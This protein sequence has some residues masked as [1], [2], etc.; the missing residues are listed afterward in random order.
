MMSR[1]LGFLTASA[2]DTVCSVHGS[3][4][5]SKVAI[6]T[7]L[8]IVLSLLFIIGLLGICFL[9]E[10]FGVAFMGKIGGCEG[11]MGVH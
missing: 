1:I 11:K 4:Q 9:G 10:V 5:P 8:F 7:H 6:L 2:A 3:M